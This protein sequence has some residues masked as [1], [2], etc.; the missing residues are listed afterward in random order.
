MAKGFNLPLER[1][2]YGM[3]YQ[4]LL[5]YSATLP[6]YEAPKEGDEKE[7]VIMMTKENEVEVRSIL[8]D[9]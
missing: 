9:E 8:F 7:E 3:S 2:L 4:N 5:L 6:S 1:V